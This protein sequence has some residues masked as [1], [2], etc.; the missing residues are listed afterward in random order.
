M[1]RPR[2]VD[3]TAPCC[4]TAMLLVTD[5]VGWVGPGQPRE[6]AT[7]AKSHRTSCPPGSAQQATEACRLS[8]LCTITRQLLHSKLSDCA[9]PST[10]GWSG[11]PPFMAE[12]SV[13]CCWKCTLACCATAA[14]GRGGGGHARVRV[15]SCAETAGRWRA[16]RVP[17]ARACLE[18]REER[19][20]QVE[21]LHHRRVHRDVQHRAHE[22]GVL[23]Q[24]HVNVGGGQLDL[25]QQLLKLG[26]PD[27]RT[28][29]RA[30]GGRKRRAGSVGGAREA[31]ARR[32]GAR[33]RRAPASAPP[34]RASA[35][36]R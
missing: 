17:R 29:T 13:N 25:V 30:Q 2:S 15:S 31:V 18:V 28:H 5:D 21:R 32:G 11:R 12:G 14:A 33:R 19:E 27:L 24:R 20:E 16:Q 1:T 36:S 3:R 4:C 22:L 35:W 23:R 34:R 8:P 9:P 7:E 26:R 10:T 6:P